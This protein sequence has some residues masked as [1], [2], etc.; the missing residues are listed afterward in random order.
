MLSSI[1]F[2]RLS[3]SGPAKRGPNASRSCAG[4]SH[5]GFGLAKVVLDFTPLPHVLVQLGG[6][7]QGGVD[8]IAKKETNQILLGFPQAAKVISRLEGWFST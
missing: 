2:R 3:A 6:G 5:Q 1:A 7:L 4:I 8:S